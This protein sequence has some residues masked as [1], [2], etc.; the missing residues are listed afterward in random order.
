ML[1]AISIVCLMFTGAILA[2]V[3]SG[4][5]LISLALAGGFI[6]GHL[7]GLASGL[8]T[9]NFLSHFLNEPEQEWQTIR[10]ETQTFDLN[11]SEDYESGI[12]L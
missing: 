10:G 1:R 4:S 12:K 2:W 3:L 5:P 7:S 6:A 8:A 9:A 11:G